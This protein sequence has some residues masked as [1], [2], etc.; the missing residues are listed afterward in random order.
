MAVRSSGPPHP[1]SFRG[2]GRRHELATAEREL[3]RAVRGEVRFGEDATGSYAYDGSIYRQVP[4]GV[5]IPKDEADVE[6]A[7]AICRRRRLPVLPRGTGTSLSGQCVNAAVVFD[8]SKYMNRILE[9]DPE[10]RLARVQPGVICDQL[11]DAAEEHH[12]T[13]GPDPATH[14]HA[15]LGGMIGNNSCGVHSIMAGKT[16]EN[17]LELDLLLADGTRMR[18]GSHDQ[19]QLDRIVAEGG[20]QG[21]IYRR[22][23]DLRDRHGD[24]IRRRYPRLPRRVSGYNLD[25]LLPEHGFN[26]AAALVGTEGTCALVLSATVRLVPSPQQRVLLVLGY[27]DPPA[28]GRV[29][30]RILEYGPIGL[31]HFNRTILDGLHEKGQ[32]RGGEDLLPAGD[33]WLLVEFGADTREDAERPARKL[34]EDVRGWD[35]RPS[36]KLYDRPDE[37]TLV[38][39]IREGGVGASRVVPRHPGW[40]GWED[41]AVPPERIGDYL[42]DFIRLCGSHGYHP[43]FFGHIGHGCVH[44]RMDWDL[45]TA[46]GIRKMRRFM[47]AAADLVVGYGGSLSGEHGDGQKLAELLPK[48]FGAEVV[49]LF[50]QFKTIWDPE[51]LLN[52]GKVVNA[53][54]LDQNL[55]EGTEYHPVP[56]RTHFTFPHDGGS[57]A[58]AAGRCFGVGKCRHLGGGTM[59]PSFMVTREEIHST[60]G[61]ARLLNEM[62]LHGGGRTGERVWRDHA[63]KQALDLCLACKGCKG[64]CPVQVDMATYKAEF[65]S[66]FYRGRL[67]PLPA[68]AMGLI[69]YW[70]RLAER[71]PWLANAALD[72]PLAS[73]AG[74][75]LVGLSARR[76]TPPFA[77]RT[78]KAWFRERGG[79]PRTPGPSVVLWPDTFNDHFHPE[80]VIAA[81]EVLERAGFRVLVPDAPLCCGRPLYDYGMLD[82][83]ERMLRRV[84]DELRPLIREGVP[85]VGLEPSCLATFRDELPNLLAG[86]QDARRLQRQSFTLAELLGQHEFE[87]P[88]LRGRALYH[89][90]CHQAAVLGTDPDL[91]LLRRLGLEVEPSGAGC[92][93]LAGSFG[94]EAG[95]KYEVSVRAGE[96]VLAPKVR[97]A[98]PDTLI[99][100]DGFSCRS[101]IEHLTGR[102]G[103]HLAEVLHLAGHPDRLGAGGTIEERYRRELGRAPRGAPTPVGVGAGAAAALVLGAGAAALAAAAI[104]ALGAKEP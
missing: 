60:R 56:V 18:V 81:T 103:M 93:G 43:T 30:T 84:V 3:R 16:S 44:T 41:A 35:P 39:D 8:F 22:L 76:R 74:K 1:A 48:M 13:F 7:L 54:R 89:P 28:C 98:D 61:R 11:R 58:E 101:Q 87:P 83:A 59:C 102:R 91:G 96:R 100:S 70:A 86:D 80:T 78:F 71:A 45:R 77:P 32:H 94:Y 26:V 25:E 65:L 38:W 37:E 73:A 104:R 62:M 17:V 2:E 52:P 31:E 69:M 47:E 75:R 90:H 53:Y 15:T 92:C 29:A 57:F 55:R 33:A 99:V 88:R 72:V 14:D 12:L 50:D 20:R 49:A 36:A 23:R 64:D 27:P 6:R 34:M 10:R 24:L 85:V 5:V 42:A 21:E 40:P 68:Y 9:L 63:V 4:L 19:D 66:H 79:S 51:R 97:A 95:E 46:A 82:L 67:R